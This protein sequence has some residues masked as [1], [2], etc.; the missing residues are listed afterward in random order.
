MCDQDTA[1]EWALSRRGFAGAGA[2]VAMLASEA[3]LAAGPALAEANVAIRTAAGTADAFF[4]RP[5]HG[6]HPGIL[7]W[8][9]IA[10]LRDAYKATARRLAAAGFAVVAVN[11]YYRSG[12]APL[13][14]GIA[15]WFTPAG[16]AKMKPALDLLTPAAIT[17]DAGAFTGWLAAQPGVSRTHGLGTVGY[18]IGGQYVVRTAAVSPRIRAAASLHGAMLVGPEADSPVNLIARS[19]AAYLF[20][21]ARNDDAKAPGDKDALKAAAAAAH[22]P[23]EIEVYAADHGWCTLDA[24]AYNNSEAERAWKR[25]LHLFAQL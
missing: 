12:H 4:V 23:A 17:A 16:Q 15:E 10:G 13:M 6:V 22:R 5:A 2:A 9:D 20:A 7:M 11:Q 19:H 25:M 1:R 21:V 8:P 24:P 18:C 3:A 14:S